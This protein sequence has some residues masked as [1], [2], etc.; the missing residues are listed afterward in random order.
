MFN[1]IK[2]KV[3]KMSKKNRIELTDEEFIELQK[4]I[5]LQNAIVNILKTDLTPEYKTMLNKL[6]KPKEI[7][8][9][10]KKRNATK[11]AHTKKINTTL[12]KIQNAI[13]LFQLEQKTFTIYSL[14]KTANLSYQ[15]VKK[16]QNLF[17]NNPLFQ[18]NL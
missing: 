17:E 18:K 3:F 6:M 11:K 13:N 4:L 8:I 15:T 14:A 2:Y 5:T 7:I 16:N 12:K 1:K 10:E 9:S